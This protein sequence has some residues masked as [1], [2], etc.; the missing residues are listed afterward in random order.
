VSAGTGLAFRNGFALAGTFEGEFSNDVESYA[1]KGS[2]RH[3]W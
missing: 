1:G 3:R 2:V